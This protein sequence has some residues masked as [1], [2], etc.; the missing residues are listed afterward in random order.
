MGAI[1]LLRRGMYWGMY[2]CVAL[3]SYSTCFE[4]NDAIVI[5]YLRAILRFLG[6]RIL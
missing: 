4:F 2:Y 1:T 3:G 6:C 5:R